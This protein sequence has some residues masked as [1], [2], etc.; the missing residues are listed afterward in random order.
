M[1]RIGKW[2]LGLVLVLLTCAAIS[3]LFVFR[4]GE[5]ACSGYTQKDAVSY[6]KRNLDGS[7]FG[8]SDRIVPGKGKLT[9]CPLQ[10][11]GEKA[12]EDSPFI[13]NICAARSKSVIGNA[14]VYPDC[15]L[16]WRRR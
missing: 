15:G 9:I 2:T 8:N 1:H 12:T 3:T 13:V 4:E 14:E 6:V 7:G 5:R 10:P 16:E 11:K